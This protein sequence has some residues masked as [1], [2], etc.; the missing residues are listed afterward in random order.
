MR[1]RIESRWPDSKRAMAVSFWLGLL[2]PVALLVVVAVVLGF[3]I[4]HVRALKSAEPGAAPD[5]CKVR[6]S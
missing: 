5:R 3:T 2:A 1:D 4:A 6:D